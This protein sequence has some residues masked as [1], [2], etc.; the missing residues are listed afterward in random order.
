MNDTSSKEKINI[1]IACHKPSYV[2]DNP[3]LCPVQVGAELTDERLKGMQPDNEGDNI[4]AKNPY[5]CELTAQYWAWKHADCDYYGFFHYRRYLAFDKVCKVQADGSIDGKRITPYIELNNVWDDLSC[6]KIDEESMRELIRDYDILTVYRERI[7]TSVYEQ[8]CRYHNRACLD[9]AIEI[10]KARH[11]EF[12]TAADRYMSSHEVYYM[13]MYIMRKDIF[14]EY[15][16]WL[17]DILEEYERCA[18]MYLSSEAATDTVNVSGC[19]LQKADIDAELELKADV[20]VSAD[21]AA[22]G[23]K[24]TDSK[25][26]PDSQQGRDDGHGLIEPR[27]MGFLAE[28]LFGIYY[29]YKLSRGAKCGELRYI[30]FY[31]TDPDAKTSNTELRSFSVGP[32]KL[33]IDMRKLN[34]LFPAGSRRRMLIRGLI[35]TKNKETDV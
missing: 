14:S 30:K 33:K 26:A 2:P 6:H 31:N 1:F 23:I 27:I 3:L 7:N 32:L 20:N 11:P 18:G 17:F 5:Y 24:D 4:S 29:T 21:K 35:I 10:L 22:A 13:N 8:Y 9:K 12:S 16:S 19:E 15:M 25:T 34:R 28:R